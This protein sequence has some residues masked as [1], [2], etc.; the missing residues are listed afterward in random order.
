MFLTQ[1]S[2]G[3]FIC[4]LDP[5]FPPLGQERVDVL[6]QSAPAGFHE[7]FDE[8]AFRVGQEAVAIGF[9]AFGQPMLWSASLDLNGHAPGTLLSL[10]LDVAG[11]NG[12]ETYSDFVQDYFGDCLEGRDNHSILAAVRPF[13]EGQIISR[14]MVK[15]LFPDANFE[16]VGGEL[17]AMG[18][19]LS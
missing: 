19:R 16:E 12:A 10:F 1:T 5:E 7:A 9:A 4:Y 6:R 13:F 8:P 17:E 18:F 11:P 3:V 2:A 15:R 14:E